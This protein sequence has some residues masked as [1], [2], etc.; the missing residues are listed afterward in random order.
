MGPVPRRGLVIAAGPG[1][2][3]GPSTRSTRSHVRPMLSKP[4]CTLLRSLTVATLVLLAVAP[5][6]FGHALYLRSEPASGGQLVAPGQVQVW[7]TEDVEPSFSKLEV[8]DGARRRVD[9]ADTRPAPGDARS[10]VVSVG[11]LPDGTYTVSWQALSAVDGH[12]TRG[13]FP[14]VVGAGGLTGALEEAPTF[15]PSVR[16]V[17]AR[18]LGYLAALALLGGFIFRPAVLAPA[19]RSAPGRPDELLAAYDRRFRRGALWTA[20]LLVGATFL[21]MVFQAA[22]AAGVPVWAALG[23]PLLQLMSTRLGLLWEARLAIGLLLALLL[24][25]ARGRLLDWVAWRSAPRCPP[26]S[27]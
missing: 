17:V 3:P 15:V 26:R 6:A 22:N 2:A 8:L 18:W 10:L 21:G 25:L 14:L 23:A 7:F 27:A 12:V 11:A 9:S 16:D 4:I 24:W 20:V 5:T 1:P 13:V 19:L